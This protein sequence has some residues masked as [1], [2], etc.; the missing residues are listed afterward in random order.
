MFSMCVRWCY[1]RWKLLGQENVSS[2]A[3]AVDGW[4][5]HKDACLCVKENQV[6]KG[7]IQPFD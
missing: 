5:I 4:H 6:M 7:Q 2:V 3:S 1:I